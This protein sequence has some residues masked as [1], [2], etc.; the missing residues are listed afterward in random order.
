[1]THQISS[2][3]TSHDFIGE[4]CVLSVVMTN[5][6]TKYDLRGWEGLFLFTDYSSPLREIHKGTQART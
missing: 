1:M 4:E 5:I 2:G 3:L 6:L